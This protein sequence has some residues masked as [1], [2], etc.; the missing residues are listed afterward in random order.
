MANDNIIYGI[1]PIQQL[2]THNPNKIKELFLSATKQDRRLQQIINLA[3][4]HDIIVQRIE[5]KKLDKLLPDQN[6]QGVMAKIKPAELLNERDLPDLVNNNKNP[7][8]LVLDGVQDPHNFGACLRTADAAGVV[9]V[10][11]PRD[12]A[13]GITPVVRKVASGAADS[14]AIVSVS[15]L[16]RALKDLQDLGVW[17]VGTAG[18]AEQYLYA[19]DLTGAIAIILGSEGDGM[20]LLTKK[21]CDYLVKI[22]MLGQ[23]ESLNVSVACGVCLYEAVRQRL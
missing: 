7:L 19:Q 6:H 11:I 5:A 22:P 9:A 4:K 2:L 13:V 12:N 21:H 17:I 18:D 20:R 8:F 23:V 10:I 15:N 14:V 1:N 16:A 3:K